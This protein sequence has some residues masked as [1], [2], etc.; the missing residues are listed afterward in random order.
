MGF[1]LMRAVFEGSL[2]ME[3]TNAISRRNLIGAG[4]AGLAAGFVN[5]GPRTAFADAEEAGEPL[6]L[7]SLSDEDL[8]ALESNLR[9]EKVRRQMNTAVV[10]QGYYVAGADFAAGTYIVTALADGNDHGR[11]V[12]V[13][14][15]Q[16][17]E[18][19]LSWD[20]IDGGESVKISLVDGNLLHLT[21]SDFA[22]TPFAVDFGTAAS[23]DAAAQEQPAADAAS[24][25]PDEVTPEFKETMD[26][27]EAFMNSYCDFMV[28][29]TDATNSGDTTTLLSMTADY[30][31]L[32][33]QEL[34]WMGKIDAID[35]NTLSPADAAYYVEVQARVSQKLIETGVALG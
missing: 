1:A 9:A 35:E 28:K 34:D 10:P 23:T 2:I 12:A 26:G 4:L 8:L 22:L 21:N 24:T 29:Y 19:Q 11:D 16:D 7:T 18:N 5:V 6:D 30:A 32:I 3:R 33:Q 15:T 31:S 13:Y 20:Y 14:D 25:N 17:Q 27:Y